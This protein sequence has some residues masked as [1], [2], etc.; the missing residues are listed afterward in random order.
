[1]AESGPPCSLD[2]RVFEVATAWCAQLAI[3]G[4][5]PSTED[6]KAYCERNGVEQISD[7]PGGVV[8]DVVEPFE[9]AP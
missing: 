4:S 8:D 2:Q 7:L 1:M 9:V 6:L 5:R 3:R